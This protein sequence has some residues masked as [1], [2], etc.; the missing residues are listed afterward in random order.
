M[1][2]FDYPVGEKLIAEGTNNGLGNWYV[3][4]FPSAGSSADPFVV[5]SSAWSLPGGFPATFGNAIEFVGGA[6]DSVIDIPDQGDTGSIYSSFVF[7]VVDQSGTSNGSSEYFFSFAKAANNG[8]SLNYTLCVYLKKVDDN[9]F[10][11][12]ISESN[13]TKNMVWAPTALIL[14][15]D[16]FVVI[17]YGI[18]NAVSKMWINPVVDDTEPATSYITNED[19][20]STRTNLTMVRM[21]L[22]SNSKTSGIILDEVRIGNVWFD[23]TSNPTASISD[24]EMDSKI[25]VYPNPAKDLFKLKTAYVTISSVEVYNVLGAKVLLQTELLDQSI[26]ILGLTNGIYFLKINSGQNSITKKL[27]IE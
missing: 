23:V 25:K 15:Q 22:G 1:M 3:P 8:T 9:T 11:L 4:S 14:N 17:Y 2:G 7:R 19:A 20:T 6:D 27:I 24:Y 18:E 12:G 26:N 16:L 13:N 10:N 21:N 5:A